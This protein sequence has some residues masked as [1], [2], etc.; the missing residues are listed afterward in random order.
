MTQLIHDSDSILRMAIAFLENL[1][2]DTPSSFIWE[3]FLQPW[4]KPVSPGTSPDN[5]KV[6]E[7]LQCQP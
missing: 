4:S 5:H 7:V 2:R 1:S 3:V 6:P